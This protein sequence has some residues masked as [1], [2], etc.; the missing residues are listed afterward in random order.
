MMMVN[1]EKRRVISS[2]IP[3]FG[4]IPEEQ[5]SDPQEK[6]TTGRKVNIL[7]SFFRSIVGP[8]F[9]D[10]FIANPYGI[11]Q[12]SGETISFKVPH[13]QMAHPVSDTYICTS[14]YKCYALQHLQYQLFVILLPLVP[15]HSMRNICHRTLQQILKD[16][17]FFAIK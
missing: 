2:M 7:R 9:P 17:Q 11:D 8:I 10:I 14:Q 5:T 16:K 6:F 15:N 13:V 3:H 12:S 1:L 4:S